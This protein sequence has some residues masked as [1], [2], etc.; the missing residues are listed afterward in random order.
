MK[1][2]KMGKWGNKIQ[3]D[4][5][6]FLMTR[7]ILVLILSLTSLS[8]SLN[9]WFHLCI[10]YS[11]LWCTPRFRTWPTPF[12]SLYNS[13]WLGDLKKFPKI[14]FVRWWHPAVHLFHTYK[15]CSISWNTYHHFQWHSLLDELEQTASQSIKNWISSHWH[16]TTTTQIFW[17]N[18]LISQQWYHPS[19]FLCSQSWL[20]LW[21]WHVLLWSNQLCI[22]ILSFSYPRHPSNSSS[23]S[24]FYSHSSCKFTCLQQ[25]WLLQF[26]LFWHLTN[27]PQQ[28]ST[29][30]KFIGTCHYKHFK[31][32]TYHTNT[33]KTTL[34]SY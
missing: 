5:S 31:I 32:S 23:S 13:S 27:K 15:F 34:A 18:K 16:K 24:S 26:T 9:Q 10:L 21:L 22:Q 14:S 2:K 4:K 28:T 29:H 8:G 17:S 7:L 12:H 20:H 33:Q 19:Q 1:K 6:I 3:I 30:S 25:T 11:F